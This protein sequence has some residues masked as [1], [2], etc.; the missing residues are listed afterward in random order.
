MYR[1]IPLLIAVLMLVCSCE[2]VNRA[3]SSA[4]EAGIELTSSAFRD[5]GA[6]PREV[7]QKR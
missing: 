3:E 2:G 7:F 5:G 1:T 4:H 6:I